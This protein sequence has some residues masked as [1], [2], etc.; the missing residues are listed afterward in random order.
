MKVKRRSLKGL[1]GPFLGLEGPYLGLFGHRKAILPCRGPFR[2]NK[3]QRRSKK[4]RE[5]IKANR[6]PFRDLFGLLGAFGPLGAFLGLYWAFWVAFL[7]LERPY[8]PAGGLFGPNKA[9]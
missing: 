2:A 6:R 8:C 4:A 7:G 5:D 9:L 1:K 3:G